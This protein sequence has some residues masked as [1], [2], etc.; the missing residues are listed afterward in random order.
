MDVRPEEDFDPKDITHTGNDL[1]IQKSFSDLSR[2]ILLESM[3]KRFRGKIRP[4]GIRTEV[5]PSGVILKLRERQQ[6][7]HRGRKDHHS[8][9]IGM[10]D[11]PCP[12]NGFVP[13]F[14]FAIK[15]PGPPHQEVNEEN[16]FIGKMDSELFPVSLHSLNPNLLE[17]GSKLFEVTK[18]EFDPNLLPL[19]DFFQTFGI[20]MN[21]RSFS[22]SSR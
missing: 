9:R 22:H 5:T 2:R 1:L 16:P 15:P 17:G 18:A 20:M 10:K 8:M 7:H 19:E 6:L 3:E 4:K 12:L 14:I 11:H 13:R 21:Q